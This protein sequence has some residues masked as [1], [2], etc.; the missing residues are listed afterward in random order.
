MGVLEEIFLIIF[1]GFAAGALLFVLIDNNPGRWLETAL[2]ISDLYEYEKSNRRKK[3]RLKGNPT[4]KELY[5]KILPIGSVVLLNEGHG[6]E[7]MIVDRFCVRKEKKKKLYYDYGAALF[8]RGAD[9]IYYFNKE[10]ISEV[11]FEGY[12]NSDEKKYED[13]Y[14]EIVKKSGIM[15]AQIDN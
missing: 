4:Y 1:V 14:D 9:K 2:K 7:Y 8:P 11:L 15:K 6:I 5:E 3:K 10:I 12:I 13:E